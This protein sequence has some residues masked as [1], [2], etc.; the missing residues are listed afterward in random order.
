MK[1][2]EYHTIPNKADWGDGPWVREPDKA[3]WR[4]PETGLPCLIVR[5]PSG[6]LCGYV[7]VPESHPMYNVEYDNVHNAYPDLSV[8]GGLTYS[9]FCDSGPTPES[10]EKLRQRAR[11]C[12]AESLQYPK[13]DSANFLKDRAKELADY[14]A[15]VV[16]CEAAHICHKVED[17]EDDHVWWLGF[18]CAHAGDRSPKY[19]RSYSRED[20]T[21]RD[22]SYVKLQVES[23]AQQLA[24]FPSLGLPAPEK[25]TMTMDEKRAER[26]AWMREKMQKLK[27]NDFD[28]AKAFG[29]DE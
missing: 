13:G 23:L 22:W 28:F 9:D 24:K 16:W 26:R 1:S 25:M 6:A 12:L 10:W 20:E 7:G 21:Y 27:D 11:D 18:D 15:Y 14:D 19:A 29:D 4:D 3:Q 8:H 5:G 17:G 2:I